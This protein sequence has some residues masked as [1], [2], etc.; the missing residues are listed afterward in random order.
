[1]HKDEILE[2]IWKYREDYGRK[3][4]FDLKKICEDLMKKQAESKLKVV[5]KAT[6]QKALKQA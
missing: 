5:T 1:M 6:P 4:D 2:E 3:F